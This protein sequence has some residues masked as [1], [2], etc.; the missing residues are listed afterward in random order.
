MCHILEQAAWEYAE[1]DIDITQKCILA[2]VCRFASV[3]GGLFWPSLDLLCEWSRGSLSTLK[4]TLKYFKEAGFI[5][6]ISPAGGE[7]KTNVYQVNFEKLGLSYN[8]LY[9]CKKSPTS[10]PTESVDK[11]ME[12]VHTDPPGGSHRPPGGSHRPGG[13]FTQTPNK[14]LNTNKDMLKT[15][16]EKKVRGVDKIGNEKFDEI[17]EKLTGQSRELWA[18]LRSIHVDHSTIR[19]WIQDLGLERVNMMYRDVIQAQRENPSH[20]KNAGA[21]LRICIESLDSQKSA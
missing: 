1:E 16:A 18:S 8:D 7:K 9:K 11:K 14:Q 6:L 3:D 2:L 20:I 10:L 5:T 13:G 12:G 4:R 21:Y 19:Q 17:Q 15:Y